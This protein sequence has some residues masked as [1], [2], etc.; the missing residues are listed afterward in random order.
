MSIIFRIII[1]GF[2]VFSVVFIWLMLLYQFVLTIG[3]FLWKRKAIKED[4]IE[5]DDNLLPSVSILIPAKNEE[6]VIASLLERIMEFD[7]PEEKL[8]VIVINDGSTDSTEKIISEIG[9]KDNRIHI[10]NIPKEEGGKGKSAALNRA[11]KE[12]SH[13]VIAIYDADNVPEKDSLRKLCKS[14]VS[15][16]R[17]AAVTGKFRA[18]NK[19]RNFLTKMINIEGIAFQWII[20]AGRWQFFNIS[21]IPGTNFVIWKHVLDELNGWDVQALTE[22]SELT[23]R[24]YEKGYLIKFLPTATTWEQEPESLR[25]WI[26][27]RTRWAR[28]NNYII[29]KYRKKIFKSKPR[30]TLVELFYMLFLY[31]FFVFAILF[32]DILFILSLFGVVHIQVFGPY[33]ELWGLAFLLY[34]LEVLIALSYEREDKFS[35]IYYILMAYLTYT[36]L[37]IVVV[38]RG[39]YQE[40][41]RKGE[42]TWAKTERFDVVPGKDKAN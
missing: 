22:D 28:G 11:L 8:E 30:M 18:Y 23:F 41:I 37:W 10:L 19:G 25:V 26:R 9:A 39:F 31:Y 14:L 2:F 24:I 17:L 13:E 12:V 33:A 38:L 6:K 21:A 5:I 42:R 35:S 7:Y 1:N 27:Q 36:K 16:K 15:D 3:G 34:V 4:S 40:Y 20:Q 32:S 29:S